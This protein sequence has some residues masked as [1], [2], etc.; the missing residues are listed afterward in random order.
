MAIK[1][2]FYKLDWVNDGSEWGNDKNIVQGITSSHTQKF[3]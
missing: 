2:K 3:D 1:A